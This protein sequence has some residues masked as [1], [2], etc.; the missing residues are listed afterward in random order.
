MV[1]RDP[2]SYGVIGAACVDE[3]EEQAQGMITRYAGHNIKPLV[4]VLFR[5]LCRKAIVMIYNVFGVVLGG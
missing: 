5:L 2:P 3:R 1:V 4:D